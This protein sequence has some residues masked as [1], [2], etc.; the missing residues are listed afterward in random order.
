MIR[1]FLAQS[2]LAGLA[3]AALSL[4][5]VA[6]AGILARV[7]VT[8]ARDWEAVARLPFEAEEEGHG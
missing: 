8:R 6:F 2:P 7:L 5:F 1:Q 3:I 4:F